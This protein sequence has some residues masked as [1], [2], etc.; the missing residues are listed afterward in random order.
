VYQAV[1]QPTPHAA[2]QVVLVV[3]LPHGHEGAA[4]EIARLADE[5][6]ATL[7][8]FAHGAHARPAVVSTSA[9]A[10]LEPAHEGL[11]VDLANRRVS[12][13]GR[14]IR[15]AY[16]EFQ[17]LAYLAATPNHTVSRATL[18]QDVWRDRGS[19]GMDV[20]DR[21]VDTHIRRLRAK[22]GDHAHV[23][24]TVRG[25]GYRLDPSADMRFSEGPLRRAATATTYRRP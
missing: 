1:A 5:F 19:A 14:P 3:D 17:L 24:T 18:L 21:T 22:L 25:R 12:I 7:P 15:L 11:T 20:S 4:A 13:A 8:Q 10:A 23:L 16:R 6:G 2:M 9:T